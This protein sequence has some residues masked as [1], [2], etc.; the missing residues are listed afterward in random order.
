M[1]LVYRKDVHKVI[2][3]SRKKITCHEGIYANF[4]PTKSETP[5]PTAKEIDPENEVSQLKELDA[6]D[7]EDDKIK[8]VHSVK[9]LRKSRMN[10]SMN[11]PLPIPPP[12]MNFADRSQ[13]ENQGENLYTAEHLLEEDSLLEK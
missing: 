5:N 9:V 1:C 10:A 3:V 13:P 11:E 2:S 12:E 8:G 4:D 6:E 7:T